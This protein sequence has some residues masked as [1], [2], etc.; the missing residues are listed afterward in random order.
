MKRLL[1]AAA[2]AALS[3]AAC[4]KSPEQDTYK[5]PYDVYV[6]TVKVD[7]KDGNTYYNENIK[8][9]WRTPAGGP[10]ELAIYQIKFV[11]A[12][13]VTINVS[14]PGIVATE[15][16]DGSIRLDCPDVD[17]WALGGPYPKY[18]VS[19]FSGSVRG[20]RLSFKLLFGETPTEFEGLKE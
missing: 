7:S 11:P 4:V 9:A 2:A 15:Q 3:L 16:E 20:D 6:G 18:R 17:P 12:M 8:V 5:G 1:I 19:G 13:P 14:I 10:D